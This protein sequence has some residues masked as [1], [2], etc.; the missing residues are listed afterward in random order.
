MRT[1]GVTQVSF[2]ADTNTLKITIPKGWHEL[3]QK[4]LLVVYKLMTIR[5]SDELPASVFRY[6]T[7]A[8]VLYDYE[9]GDFLM[10]SRDRHSG[11]YKRAAR[12][13][14]EQLTD[15]FDELSWLSSPGAVPVRLKSMKGARA[16]NAELHGVKFKDYLMLEN[17]YQGY[18]RSKNEKAL[19]RAAAI[20]YPGI[21]GT[22]LHEVEVLNILQ[23]CVQLKNLFAGTFHNLFKEAG[24]ESEIS[25]L[26]IMNNEIRAL[27][28]GD[29]TKEDIV[30]NTECWRALTELDYKAKEA[31]DFKA[32][33]PKK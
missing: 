23:W 20:L 18:L 13:S 22:P 4:E 10:R 25:Q 3:T 7:Q 2:S 6:L 19:L 11:L 17:S 24:D 31:E 33:M 15:V 9:S 29:V 21:K 28:G 32:S 5:D 1:K 12:M 26:E 14:V 30:L 16:V 27:T 8:S